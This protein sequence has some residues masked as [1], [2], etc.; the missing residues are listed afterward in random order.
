[1]IKKT[2]QILCGIIALSGSIALTNTAY[3]KAEIKKPLVTYTVLSDSSTEKR[4]STYLNN[5]KIKVIYRISKIGYFQ[6]KLGKFQKNRFRESF[7]NVKIAKT[8]GSTVEP[9]AVVTNTDNNN[10]KNKIFK[11]EWDVRAVTQN[12]V[13]YKKMKHNRTATVAVI[14]SGIDFKLS[15]LKDA[16][17][18]AQL[19][20]VPK[21]GYE[22]Q[23]LDE[24]GVVHYNVDKTGHGS[25]VAGEIAGVGDYKGVAPGVKVKSYR[26]FGNGKSK[27]SWI[28]KAITTAANDKVDVINISAGQYLNKNNKLD[29]AD[30]LAYR[31]A[32]NLA[33]SHNI[34]VVAAVGDEGIDENNH[35]Q[36]VK[37]YGPEDSD[38]KRVRY[39]VGDYPANFQSVIGVGSSNAN[40]IKSDFSNYSLTKKNF[41]LAPGGDTRL[42]NEFGASVWSHENLVSKEGIL[43]LNPTEQYSYNL[44]TSFAAPKVAGIL[45]AIRA[46]YHDSSKN[47]RE[48]LFDAAK[49]NAEGYKILNGYLALNE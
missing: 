29:K 21:G 20:F 40:N 2:T 11:L 45:A 6:V 37:A 42:L 47:A 33:T 1:M 39:A 9:R 10:L 12:G 38:N 28:I 43:V 26:V 24:K 30:I 7:P 46:K 16:K 35:D 31:K 48:R 23:E 18:G 36:M 3:V 13:A 22:N 5:Q 25:A 34:N 49:N 44:G 19:N 15:A 41:I 32:I 27:A 14:D 17:K 8:A 4:V